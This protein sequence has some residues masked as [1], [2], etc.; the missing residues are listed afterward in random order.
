MLHG[1]E[2]LIIGVGYESPYREL[3]LFL[4]RTTAR[5]AAYVRDLDEE[6]QAISSE[7]AT[8]QRHE[9]YFLLRTALQKASSVPSWS[10]LDLPSM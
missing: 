5:V 7:A 3:L 8:L 2:R 10:P 9:L 4:A 6:F 1:T